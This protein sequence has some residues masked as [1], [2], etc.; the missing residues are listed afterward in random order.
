MSTLPIVLI[1][2]L[3]ALLPS[4]AFAQSDSTPPTTAASLDPSSPDGDN[5][6]YR[7]PLSITLEA[8]DL[9]SGVKYINWKLD[10]GDWE[11]ETFSSSLNLLPNPSFELDSDLDNQPDSWDFTGTSGAV[12]ELDSSAYIGSKS[13]EISAITNG[14]SFFSSAD[15]YS[16]VDPPLSMYFS[17]WLRGKD[18]AGKGA[19]FKIYSLSPSGSDL[20]YSAEPAAFSGSFDWTRMTANF[21]LLDTEIYGLYAE[22]G[23]EGIGSLWMDGAVLAEQT[24]EPLVNLTYFQNGEH[25]FYYYSEDSAGNKEVE[26]SLNF[27]IDTVAP[28]NWRDF[29]VL[30]CALSND[31]TLYSWI[32]VSDYTSG[33]QPF[34]DEFQYSIDAGATWGYYDDLNKCSG[35][36]HTDQWRDLFS[37]FPW[38][39]I[40]DLTL[41]TPCINYCN[42]NWTVCKI[43]RFRVEDMAGNESIKDICINGAW[44]KIRGGGDVY[45]AGGINM[46]ASGAD[47]NTDSLIVSSGT[48]TNFSST[49]PWN[50]LENYSLLDQLHYSYLAGKYDQQT[51]VSALPVNSGYYTT[52]GSFVIDNKTIPANLKSADF[53]AVLFVPGDLTINKDF[54]L[55]RNGGLVFVVSG[56]IQV[57]K[58]VENISGVFIAEGD[59]DTAY[60][61]GSN[62]NTLHIWGAVQADTVT[63]TRSLGRRQNIDD[64]AE[65]IHFAPK[66]FWLFD[67]LLGRRQIDWRELTD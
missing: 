65:Y 23:L 40:E 36:W 11:R 30:R 61:G 21:D 55:G 63:L 39:G 4:P 44:I 34:T 28:T 62:L 3:V 54:E 43:V 64:P 52:G 66:Y 16:V 1:S 37:W 56:N 50:P 9:E 42:S 45:S 49:K 27:K 10:S 47:P 48:V 20:L 59:F 29:G 25:T 31:H 17:V 32:T 53:S 41:V 38:P 26:Q 14:W 24:E 60:N 2:L 15:N 67:N 57:D 51:A 58:R 6:W 46:D 33:L 12:G 35:T 18:I 13:A 19:Y 5:N 8:S 7:S 22:I